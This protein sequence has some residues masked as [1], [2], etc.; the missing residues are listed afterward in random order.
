MREGEHPDPPIAP[1][2]Y[3]LDDQIGFLLRQAHQAH[4]AIFAR[5]FGD[6]FTPMQWAVIAKLDEIGDCSQ[7]L[8]GR[9][10][11]MDV[12]TIKGVVERLAKR[13]FAETRADA[14]DRRRVIVALTPAGRGAFR[15]A[16][17]TAHRVS[18]ETL[19]PLS[20]ADRHTVVRLL[21]QLR[22]G[23]DGRNAPPK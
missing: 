20:Q 9:L 14:T 6:D 13:G 17:A 8:L 2:G 21:K 19:E 10:T 15:E 5:H 18:A 11:A 4:A 16:A 12:A 7:N 23:D 22:P 3:C 1:R